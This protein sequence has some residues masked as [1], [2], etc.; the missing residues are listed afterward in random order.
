MESTH[1]AGAITPAAGQSTTNRYGEKTM[2]RFAVRRSAETLL[3][4]CLEKTVQRREL[5][6][7]PVPTMIF[8]TRRAGHEPR[9]RCLIDSETR[10]NDTEGRRRGRALSTASTTTAP[11]PRK[12]CLY[13][14]HVENRGERLKD[15][16]FP[17]FLRFPFEIGRGLIR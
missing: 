12:T 2:L 5:Y 15:G 16:N 7:G 3:D 4:K 9:L 1:T 13:D 17:T 8:N 11:T 6:T 10:S 14:L